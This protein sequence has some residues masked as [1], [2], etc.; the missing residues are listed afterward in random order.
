MTS[1][2]TANNGGLAT[3][4]EFD[5]NGDGGSYEEETLEGFR[6]FALLF[7]FFTFF[8]FQNKRRKIMM[9]MRS[10][11][12]DTKYNAVR[13]RSRIL[14]IGFDRFEEELG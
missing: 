1:T 7:I 3:I 9:E 2:R 8:F 14:R 4:L 12:F 11:V 6:L 10:F 13:K 5:G